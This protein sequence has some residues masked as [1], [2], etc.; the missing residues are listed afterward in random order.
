MLN[1]SHV[2]ALPPVRVDGEVHEI[3][4]LRQDP[5]S[6]QDVKQRC[7]GPLGDIAPSLL[8]YYFGDLAAEGKA[9]EI[10][11]G[12]RCRS[13]HHSLNREAPARKSAALDSLEA[14]M[15]STHVVG[16]RSLGN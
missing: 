12:I 14:I 16:E 1:I 7:S 3:P 9:P 8:A 2:D 4:R 13:R 6:F 15:Q 5:G 11:E 10:G